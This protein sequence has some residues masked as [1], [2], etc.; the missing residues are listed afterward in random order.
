MRL[1]RA[2]NWFGIIP[3]VFILF[4]GIGATN[5]LLT[6]PAK[7]VTA[8]SAR[9]SNAKSL[10]QNMSRALATIVV[11]YDRQGSDPQRSRAGALM[12]N[13]ARDT[14]VRLGE[15]EAA[16]NT[17]N[18][19]KISLATSKM[20]ES[21]GRLQGIHRMTAARN[22]AVVEGVRALCANWATYTARYAL[23]SPKKQP[24]A[25]SRTQVAELQRRVARLQGE[26]QRLR[27]NV[28]VNAAL[29]SDV[30]DLYGQIERLQRR[31]VTRESYQVTLVS[32]SVIYGV[33]DGYIYVTSVYYPRYYD[34][35]QAEREYFSFYHGYWAGYYDAYYGRWPSNYYERTFYAPGTTFVNVDVTIRQQVDVYVTQ[36]INVLV[37]DADSVES[38]FENQPANEQDIAN[39][40]AAV[41]I[42]NVATEAEHVAR[43]VEPDADTLNPLEPQAVPGDEQLR[44]IEEVSPSPNVQPVE[45]AAPAHRPA[46]DATRPLNDQSDED[47]GPPVRG[48]RRGATAAPE[49]NDQGDEDAGPP[50]RGDRRGATAAPE[51]NDQADEEPAPVRPDRSAESAAPASN[52]QP[53]QAT[54]TP[55][56][57]EGA[58][59]Q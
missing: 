45:G 50:V 6:S 8:D 41:A 43:S 55:A 1:L 9:S 25:A 10:M 17:R 37:H 56:E 32:L 35:F 46:E 20:S 44:P 14:A 33:F 23:A 34:Y 59:P 47:A 28:A 15:L 40:T 3:T 19:Q 54:P 7:A 31:R 38:A 49:V 26:V 2:R 4:A 29:A 36:N 53:T 11:A 57:E 12:L 21:V 52:D 22:P 27:K 16:L 58:D 24:A 30:D 13:G 5:D 51:V 18:P 39:R 42:T 48:D